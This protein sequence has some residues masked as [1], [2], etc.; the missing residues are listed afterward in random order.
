MS[1]AKSRKSFLIDSLLEERQRQLAAAAAARAAGRAES[2]ED[3]ELETAGFS[4]DSNRTTAEAE[5]PFATDENQREEDRDEADDEEENEDDNEKMPDLLD[6]S[7]KEDEERNTST[8]SPESPTMTPL[9]GIPMALLLQQTPQPNV[10]AATLSALAA[11][12]ATSPF[13]NL[14]TK[15]LQNGVP[16]SLA[17][18][19][20]GSPPANTTTFAQSVDYFNRLRAMQANP[21]VSTPPAL[22]A[23]AWPPSGLLAAAAAATAANGA[24]PTIASPSAFDATKFGLPPSSFASALPHPALRGL[25]MPGGLPKAPV[26]PSPPAGLSAAL[27]EV[28]RRQ[29]AAA[30]SAQITPISSASTADSAASPPFFL[31]QAS[32]KARPRITD[33]LKTFA[34]VV[35][36]SGRHSNH[37]RGG[38]LAG[39]SRS[40]N[41]KKYR[42]D[43]VAVPSAS[44]AT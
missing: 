41:V 19:T 8:H 27:E 33:S 3:G 26:V 13:L 31:P 18:T 9:S 38:R 30:M 15:L 16:M 44:P 29:R 12:V 17:A 5:G 32:P 35:S 24:R 37:G 7:M 43:V 6:P 4:A 11:S 21:A 14:F 42:C 36:G 2:D 28:A 25:L 40:S 39:V 20:A 34:G 22:P 10:N 23:A 1:T